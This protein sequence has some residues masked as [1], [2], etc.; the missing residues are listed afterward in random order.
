MTD[1]INSWLQNLGLE[2]YSA[3]FAEHD[4]DMEVL[5]D[6][7]DNDL[8][9]LGITLG[10]RRRIL[11]AIMSL[12]ARGPEGED[13]E[14]RQLT[15]LF[16]DLVGSTRLS[17]QFDPE[18]LRQIILEYQKCCEKVVHDF[19]GN[20]ARYMGDGLLVYFG[21]PT[22]YEDA[23]ERAIRAGTELIAAVG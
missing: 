6:L 19:G 1:N 2:Q 20:V 7:D 8:K 4:V 12:Q 22:A 23:P 10:H 9:E 5:P 3:V 18:D 14:R 21:Y 15:V 11:K 16:C 17:V 13:G